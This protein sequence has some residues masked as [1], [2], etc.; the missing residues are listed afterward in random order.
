MHRNDRHSHPDQRRVVDRTD[1]R[2]T[3]NPNDHDTTDAELL[4]SDDDHDPATHDHEPAEQ[5]DGNDG[6]AHNDNHDGAPTT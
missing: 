6:A 1:H 2:A 3:V 5:H 4:C